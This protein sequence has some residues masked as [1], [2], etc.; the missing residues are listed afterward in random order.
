[1]TT[2]EIKP[3]TLVAVL[4]DHIRDEAYAIAR[5][6]VEQA[7]SSDIEYSTLVEQFVL[8][9]S[10]A[11]NIIFSSFSHK[12]FDEIRDT[13][14]LLDFSIELKTRYRKSETEVGVFECS[15]DNLFSIGCRLDHKSDPD[16]WAKDSVE[17][18][19]GNVHHVFESFKVKLASKLADI[20]GQKTEVDI[21]LKSE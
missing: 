12:A 14:M 1:M 17:A 2:S 16:R 18:Y 10:K 11:E 4:A 19:G 20:H 21:P 7:K 9:K 6:I 15:D 5:K 3:R 13:D 8:Q